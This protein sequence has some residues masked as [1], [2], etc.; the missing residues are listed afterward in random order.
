MVA[1][2]EL[3]QSL[4][5]TTNVSQQRAAG[6]AGTAILLSLEAPR[7]YAPELELELDGAWRELRERLVLKGHEHSVFSAAFSPDGKR[8]VTA[9][10]DNTAR[11]WDAETGKQIGEPPQAIRTGRVPPPARRVNDGPGL[12]KRT[13]HR[14][15]TYNS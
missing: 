14:A 2:S 12:A 10:D 15:W 7:P 11:L 9:S 8:I 4:V 13:T 3:R 1:R 5:L 6:D